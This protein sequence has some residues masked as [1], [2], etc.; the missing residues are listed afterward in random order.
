MAVK[1]QYLGEAELIQRLMDRFCVP[2]WAFFSHVRNTTGF[3]RYERT[4]DA[5]AM[6][7]YPSRGLEL[8]G[9]EVKSSRADFLNELKNPD[10]ATEIQQYCDR[11]WLTI[12]NKDIVKDG[13][14][15]PT[16]GLIIPH[17]QK[18]RVSVEAPK[19][20]A[21]P[22][23][24]RFIASVLR[25]AIN[26]V[27]DQGALDA[28]YNRGKKEGIEYSNRINIIST[29][30]AERKIKELQQ[31]IDDFRVKSGM[32][33]SKWNAGKIGDAVRQIMHAP[34]MNIILNT[35]T[36]DRDQL[37]NYIKQIDGALQI[38]TDFHKNKKPTEC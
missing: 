18:V 6:N 24:R 29:D 36:S 1:K 37:N 2:E 34:T 16:W 5:I 7:C 19:L 20:E 3:A 26:T 22:I 38:L 27:T 15:P 9:F 31:A 14:L 28:A 4:A 8:H 12:G 13:E 32:D 23:S 10:K 25:K 21:K 11:W 35:L 33:I 30:H 17:G